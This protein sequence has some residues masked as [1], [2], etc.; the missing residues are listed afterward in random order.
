MNLNVK[1][2]NNVPVV[3][4]DEDREELSE[5]IEGLLKK[6][7]NELDRHSSGRI[8]MD[9]GD[10]KH[11]NSADLGSIIRFKDFLSDNNMT[12]ILIN[13]SEQTTEL[14]N[15]VGLNEFFS[16]VDSVDKI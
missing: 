6:K 4:V 9:L 1:Y 7:Y 12:L 11:F 2:K 13:P 3:K 15:M 10:K 16:I 5:M 8:A 14:F